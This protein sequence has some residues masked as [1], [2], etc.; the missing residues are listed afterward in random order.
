[1]S[2]AP[3]KG[4]ILTGGH[5]SRLHPATKAVSKQLLAVYDK[6]VIYYPLGVLM[7]MNVREVLIIANECDIAG[8]RTL[9][10]DG[11]QLGIS[12]SCIPEND[13]KGIAN[14]FLLGKEFIGTDNV[15]LVLGDNIFCDTEQIIAATERYSRGA[16]TFGAKVNNPAEFGVVELDSNGRVLSI[17]EKPAH[18]KSNVA[19]TG[20]YVYDNDVVKIAGKL[21]PSR[22]GELEITDV[23]RVY[24]D[25]GKLEIEV[26]AEE[27]I[28]FDTGTADGM[29]LAGNYIASIERTTGQ[30]IGCL[31][32]IAYRKGLV[33]KSRAESLAHAMPQC[34][35]REYL[36]SVLRER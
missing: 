34:N 26:L 29:L 4:I 27:V 22:R 32:E 1:M 11:S 5:G 16:L 18:P 2:H 21:K 35:Y 7:E 36:L 3:T 9:L 15:A 23:N 13:P 30:K 24:L 12:I 6:P 17:E 8:F 19:V 14:A 28:W 33:S 20:L 31:E 25:K 10:G